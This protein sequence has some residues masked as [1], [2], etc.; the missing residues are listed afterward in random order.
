MLTPST[1]AMGIISGTLVE[2]SGLVS[3]RGRE[4]NG[5]WGLVRGKTE[6]G[7]FEVEM[8][9]WRTNNA[10]YADDPDALVNLKPVNV[11]PLSKISIEKY[12]HRLFAKYIRSKRECILDVKGPHWGVWSMYETMGE[13]F[14]Q[15]WFTASLQD[16]IVMCSLLRTTGYVSEALARSQKCV[17]DVSV[18][19]L[20]QRNRALGE[21]ALCLIQVGCFVEALDA[22]LEMDELVDLETV[23]RKEQALNSLVSEKDEKAEL[24]SVKKRALDSLAEI[25]HDV[26][27][28]QSVGDILCKQRKFLSAADYY[29]RALEVKPNCEGLKSKLCPANLQLDAEEDDATRQAV[30]EGVHCSSDHRLGSSPRRGIILLCSALL[31]G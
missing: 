1:D 5:K 23:G 10:L 29:R 22:T 31:S 4:M 14:E 17:V 6:A 8:L 12:G 30:Q 21:L 24:A 15:P 7:R 9:G 16:K 3:V 27:T 13:R 28:L 11:K 2:T 20:Q 25:P 26:E 18:S 19:D